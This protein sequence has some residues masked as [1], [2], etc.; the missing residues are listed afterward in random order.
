MYLPGF[1]FIPA[2]KTISLQF[3]KITNWTPKFKKTQQPLPPPKK[4]TKNAPS[5]PD[6]GRQIRV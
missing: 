4:T 2:F 1:F 5:S 6:R 3:F